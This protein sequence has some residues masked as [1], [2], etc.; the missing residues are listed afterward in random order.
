MNKLIAFILAVFG[1]LQVQ[2]KEIPN[3]FN[4]PRLLNDYAHVIGE[5]DA[6]QIENKLKAYFDSTST[7]IAVV[8]ENSLEGDDLFDYS[9]RLAQ[10]WGIG[11]KGRNN[12]ILI[13]LAVDDRKVRIHAGYGMEATITDALSKRIINQIFKPY[14]KASQYAEGID[15]GTTAIMQ[16]ASGEFVND[17]EGAT[18]KGLSIFQLFLIFG[19]IFIFFVLSNKGGG[20]NGRFRRSYTPPFYGSFGSGGFGGGSDSGFGGF[21]G[22]SFGGGG[23]SGSW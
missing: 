4:P 2:S 11:E 13:Y 3:Q 7:Q 16:A 15:A 14:F 1:F 6:V 21:G 10:T 12:G 5:G 23:A 8:I 18:G 17:L 22:G 20:G 9:Q 19:V